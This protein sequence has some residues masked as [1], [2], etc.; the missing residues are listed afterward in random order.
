MRA[1]LLALTVLIVGELAVRGGEIAF[2]TP[3][4]DRWHYPFNFNPGRRATASCF[5]STADPN[6]TT[7][8]DRDG[9][10]IIAW[11]T[12]NEI[13]PELPPASYGVRGVRITLTAAVCP[14]CPVADW[15]VDLTPDPW[16]NLDYP[17]TDADPGQPLELFGAGFGPVYTAENW[18]ETSTYVGGD[19]QELTPRDPFPFVFDLDGAPLH[20]EDSVKEA[21]TP[22][23]W[24]VGSPV[25][26]VPG[27]QTV[28]FPVHFDV[29]LA[30]SE[31]RVRNYFQEQLSAGRVVVVVTSLTATFK[32]ASTGFPTFFTKEGI[33]L[34]PGARPPRLIIDF[35][36]TA[37][38]DGD[39]QR[40]LADW[41][42]LTDCFHGPDVPPLGGFFSVEECLCLFDGDQ[43]QDVDFQDVSSFQK[44]FGSGE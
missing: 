43:D 20:V 21:F 22:T 34:H 7:F 33:S 29:N 30:S 27:N 8:N 37:D 28:P 3:S 11:R 18:R 24:A 42:A 15:E 26:Y 12:D 4:D 31:G 9:A 36:P 44:R 5:G 2:D 25:G 38:A 40:D 35:V 6:F 10:F 32:Q 13:C 1:A 14:T 16:F 19:D 41:S 39:Q 23:P 17:I